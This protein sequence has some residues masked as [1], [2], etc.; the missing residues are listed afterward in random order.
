MRPDGQPMLARMI[1]SCCAA[2]ARPIKVGF[3]GSGPTGLADD[4]WVEIEGT[5]SDQR[6]TDA[7]NGEIIPFIAV[8]AWRP[9]PTTKEQYE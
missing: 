9:V 4:S 7:V 6:V 3:A 2:D 5:Y 1:L 8:S